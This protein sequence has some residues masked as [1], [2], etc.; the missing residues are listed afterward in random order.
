MTDYT[1]ALD[2]WQVKAVCLNGV[3]NVVAWEQ[4]LV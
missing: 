1:G 3:S 2:Y 4:L